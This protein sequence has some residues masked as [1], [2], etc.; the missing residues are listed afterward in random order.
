MY[1]IIIIIIII[2]WEPK[3][4]TKLAFRGIPMLPLSLSLSLSL[5]EWFSIEFHLFFKIRKFCSVNICEILSWVV[6]VI[7][8]FLWLI[9]SSNIWKFCSHSK[10]M[11]WKVFHY[12]KLKMWITW[13]QSAFGYHPSF[14]RKRVGWAKGRQRQ[15][16]EKRAGGTKVLPGIRTNSLSNFRSKRGCPWNAPLLGYFSKF[17][18]GTSFPSPC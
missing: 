5:H 10:K 2:S 14:L 17:T 13:V 4:E 11:L 12:N 6:I 7:W 3:G 1:V 18:L 8:K 16:K 9:P 15:K